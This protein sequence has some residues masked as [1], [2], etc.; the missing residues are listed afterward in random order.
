NDADIR[1]AAR[2][3]TSAVLRGERQPSLD[4]ELRASSEATVVQVAQPSQSAS[5]FQLGALRPLGE[6]LDAPATNH[7]YFVGGYLMRKTPPGAG[8]TKSPSPVQ[9][10][11][12]AEPTTAQLTATY[13]RAADRLSCIQ[14]RSITTATLVGPSLAI[15]TSSSKGQRINECGV[16]RSL[17]RARATHAAAGT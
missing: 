16:R 3:G 2:A 13:P 14:G 11:Q 8:W 12:S 5:Q 10:G 7:S 6:R 17:P 4:A 15:G 9:Q 1:P